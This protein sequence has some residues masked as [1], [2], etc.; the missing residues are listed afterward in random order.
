MEYCANAEMDP[1]K[2]CKL[3]LE[4]PQFDY[5]NCHKF[6]SR[7]ESNNNYTKNTSEQPTSRWLL[8]I[9]STIQTYRQNTRNLYFYVWKSRHLLYPQLNLIKD[10]IE[11]CSV[12]DIEFG[13]LNC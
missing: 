6:N 8:K 7:D 2:W 5:V 9:E 11:S 13:E 10:N 4:L 1:K 12:Q 3:Q